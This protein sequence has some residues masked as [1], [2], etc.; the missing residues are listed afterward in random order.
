MKGFVK[1]GAVFAL[2]SRSNYSVVT[3]WIF[4]LIT[5]YGD[6][7]LSSCVIKY[8]QTDSNLSSLNSYSL[9]PLEEETEADVRVVAE[10]RRRI[11]R[12]RRRW[13]GGGGGG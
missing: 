5:S 13:R 3:C 10:S 8:F 1:A 12:A 11:A 9:L 7:E 4:E 2:W 6:T